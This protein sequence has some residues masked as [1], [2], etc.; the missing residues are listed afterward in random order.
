MA[1]T[2]TNTAVETPYDI[3]IEDAGPA[4]KKVTVKIPKDKVSSKIKEQYKELRTGALIPGFR[5]GHAPQKL[6]QR[7]FDTDI[8]DQVKRTLISESYQHAIEQNELKVLGEPDFETKV[9]DIQV[10]EETDATYSFTIEVQPTFD[11][12]DYKGIKVKKPKITVTEDHINQAM[13]NLREQQGQLVPVEDRGIQEKDYLIADVHAKVDGNV[14]AHQHDAQLVVRPGRLAGLMISD[15]PQQMEGAKPGE[16]RTINVKVPDDSPNENLRGKDVAIEINVKDIKRIELVEIDQEFLDSLGFQNEQELRDALKEQM[17]ERI[18]FDVQQAMR[19]QVI[20]HLL[21]K[22]NIDLPAKLSARQSDRVVNRRAVDLM[23]RGLTREQIEANVERLKT[24]AQEEGSRELKTFFI[25][26]RIAE[27]LEVDVS[28][29]ELNGRIA[30]IAMQQGRRPEKVKQEMSKDGTTLA[31]LYVQMREEKALD[32]ILKSADIE[33]VE[34][35]AEQQ[36][37]VTEPGAA[38]ESSS[39]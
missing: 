21:E 26:Q 23:M 27:Q 18:T 11:V 36:K 8:K 39:T 4:T 25:L 17:D 13:Q 9:D 34:P 30:M 32:E 3:Q 5:K 35:T 10:T 29:A 6:L 19:R 12:P 14:V 15:L 38:E 24:G 1:D 16:T 22:I 20:T 28:E 37:A 2:A 31:N 7:K 33:E